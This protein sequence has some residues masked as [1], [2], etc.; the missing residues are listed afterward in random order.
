MRGAT[1]ITA[2]GRDL[3]RLQEAGQLLAADWVLV[4]LASFLLLLLA[5]TVRPMIVQIHQDLVSD[6][7]G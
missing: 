3:L 6:R 5:R 7:A 4:L 2:L 1:S